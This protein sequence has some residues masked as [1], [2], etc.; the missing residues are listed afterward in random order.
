MKIRDGFSIVELMAVVAILVI[1]AAYGIPNYQN[2][3]IRAKVNNAYSMSVP[4][5][6]SVE[7][8][9]SLNG[10][11]PSTSDLATDCSCNTGYTGCVGSI[12]ISNY[13]ASISYYSDGGTGG[14]SNY[15]ATT[16][17]AQI[18]ITLQKASQLGQASE[19]TIII[20]VDPTIYNNQGGATH[21]NCR[22]IQTLPMAY[23]PP[24]FKTCF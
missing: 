3:L 20:G 18:T 4:C 6:T 22:T 21:W 24:S 10:Y 5:Q 19:K 14:V 8:F 23:S 9:S 11:L 7:K 17:S 13:I 16:N 12:P 1:I 15:S 2:F